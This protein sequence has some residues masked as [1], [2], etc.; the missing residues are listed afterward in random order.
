M[1]RGTERGGSRRDARRGSGHLHR[2]GDV[3]AR[4]MGGP[5][6]C[7]HSSEE[8]EKAL[9]AGSDCAEACVVRR[10]DGVGAESA[11]AGA[12]GKKGGLPGA[13]WRWGVGFPLH[14]AR[15]GALGLKVVLAG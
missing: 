1:G 3:T 8:D 6:A 4:Q 10:N 11:H 5:I 14:V 13:G 15:R 2:R 9:P 12:A 7:S